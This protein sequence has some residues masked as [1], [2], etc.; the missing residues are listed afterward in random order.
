MI[1]RVPKRFNCYQR[2]QIE[3]SKATPSILEG[4]RRSPLQLQLESYQNTHVTPPGVAQT[5]DLGYTKVFEASLFP[6][7]LS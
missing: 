7:E 4:I 6:Q 3:Q 1:H 5:W 2:K